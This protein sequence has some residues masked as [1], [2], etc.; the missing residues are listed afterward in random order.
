MEIQPG[1]YFTP[2]PSGPTTDPQQD[3]SSALYSLPE[4]VA[5]DLAYLH[6]E[7]E[8]LKR[9]VAFLFKSNEEMREADET[10][11]DF[12]EAISE[13][14]AV[15]DRQSK[16]IKAIELKIMQ[17]SGPHRSEDC[18]G[19]IVGPAVRSSA[20]APPES[21]PPTSSLGAEVNAAPTRIDSSDGV[22]L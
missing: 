20:P 16:A 8:R 2:R 9:S 21:V 3:R 5:D 13:N 18:L 1:I 22:F 11:P 7:R 19:E 4:A 10:D 17:L 6:N 12:L 14:I 15:I